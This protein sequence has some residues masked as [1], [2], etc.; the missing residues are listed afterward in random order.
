MYNII[1]LHSVNP[2]DPKYT[3]GSVTSLLGT[4]VKSTAIQY[5]STPLNPIFVTLKIFGHR[6]SW[7]L[8]QPCAIIN[9]DTTLLVISKKL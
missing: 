2:N 1:F 3:E 4:P 6:V 7:L 9:D 8:I 5:N